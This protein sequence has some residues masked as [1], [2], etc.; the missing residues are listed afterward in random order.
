MSR[1]QHVEYEAAEIVYCYGGAGARLYA[2]APLLEVRIGESPLQTVL[3]DGIQDLVVRRVLPRAGRPIDC[4]P[5]SV[6]LAIVESDPEGAS[7]AKE[8]VLLVSLYRQ[9]SHQA[10]LSLARWAEA[11]RTLILEVLPARLVPSRLPPRHRALVSRPHLTVAPG[12]GRE[13]RT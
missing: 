13:A 10:L 1:R 2:G 8:A 7:A 3:Y 5:A 12:R 6:P 11:E 4:L 9:G